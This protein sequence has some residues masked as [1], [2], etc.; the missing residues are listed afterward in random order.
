MA[1]RK[2]PSRVGAP[3]SR[4]HET[5]LRRELAIMTSRILATLPR[6]TTEAQARSLASAVRRQFSA[7][8][9]A[10]MV[11]KVG[12]AAERSSSASWQKIPTPAKRSD[13]V[14]ADA[15]PEYDGE[16]L[17][18]Q[19]AKQASS[20]IT[21]VRDEAIATIETDV[22]DAVASGTTGSELAAKWRR[23]GIPLKFGTLQGRAQVI[24]QNQIAILHAEVQST[25]ARSVGAR[26]FVWHSQG[27]SRVR[28][29][30]AALDGRTFEYDDPPA[31]EGLPGQP[32]NCRCWAETVID[33]DV[34]AAMGLDDTV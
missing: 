33:D 19:W 29:A 32:I 23:E 34:L 24:A 25:R 10:T 22:V 5:T 9:I 7:R 2:L 3:L 31:G 26:E 18:A 8:A 4:T 20:T 14:R 1:R 28:P 17:L 13:A 6:V 11:E 27:D 30:H 15:L 16:K 12:R 21:S